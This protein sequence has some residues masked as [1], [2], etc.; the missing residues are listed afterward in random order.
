MIAYM[1]ASGGPGH[2]S[3]LKGQDERHRRRVREASICTCAAGAALLGSLFPIPGA[4]VDRSPVGGFRRDLQGRSTALHQTGL[5]VGR[6]GSR[7][8]GLLVRANKRST[9]ISAG[10]G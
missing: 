1:T 4:C 8:K 6:F 5:N 2:E 7:G 9:E 3:D 10:G